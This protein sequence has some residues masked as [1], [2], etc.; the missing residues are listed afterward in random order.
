[1]EE[2]PQAGETG[3]LEGIM[4]IKG[5]PAKAVLSVHGERRSKASLPL[6]ALPLGGGDCRA[7]EADVRRSRTERNG[8]C[9]DEEGH[10]K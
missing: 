1:M 3:E 8:L 2:K 6:A 9:D 5:A 7:R 10:V 4:T